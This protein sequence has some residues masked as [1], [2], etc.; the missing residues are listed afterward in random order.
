MQETKYLKKNIRKI[1]T[2]LARGSK[3]ILVNKFI[4]NSSKVVYTKQ[5][6]D[7]NLSIKIIQ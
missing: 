5:Y 7:V 2:A 6:L 1:K 4:E 3:V